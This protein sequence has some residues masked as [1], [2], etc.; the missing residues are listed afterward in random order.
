MAGDLGN[1]YQRRDA[2]MTE[3]QGSVVVID[4]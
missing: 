4:I 2:T 1:V 3:R